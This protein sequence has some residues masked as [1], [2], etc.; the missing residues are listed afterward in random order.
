MASP[1]SQTIPVIAGAITVAAL[2]AHATDELPAIRGIPAAPQASDAAGLEAHAQF[3]RE[4]RWIV[5]LE[6][7]EEV[8][9]LTHAASGDGTARTRL[10]EGYQPVVVALA[11]RVQRRCVLLD[12]LDLAQEGTIG[13]MHAIDRQKHRAAGTPFRPWALC[14]VRNAMLQAIYRSERA[15]RLPARTRKRLRRL[16]ATQ[17]ELLDALGREATTDELAAALGLDRQTVIDL[18]LLQAERFT[19]LDAPHAAP[20]GGRSGSDTLR[21]S[22][23]L[24]TPPAAAFTQTSELHRWLRL[25]VEQLPERERAVM[26]LR[27]GFDGDAAHDTREVA[28][29]LG[30]SHEAV[31][32]VDRRVRLRIKVA[33]ERWRADLEQLPFA[34]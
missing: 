3:L 24:A 20:D 13:L 19:S 17:L 15:I 31:R 29:I 22:D 2:A 1:T 5:P 33:I 28:D 11:R 21:L 9:L 27:Y 32:D 10:I 34:A 26:T 7:A 25:V 8:R 23:T 18:L 16:V 30:L 14:W 4:V 12:L 6:E